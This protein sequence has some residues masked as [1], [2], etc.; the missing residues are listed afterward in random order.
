MI[1]MYLKQKKD[2]E[3]NIT[4]NFWLRYSSWTGLYFAAAKN[5]SWMKKNGSCDLKPLF[6]RWLQI[7]FIN[8]CFDG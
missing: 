6:L 1:Y 5:Q 8:N 2:K 4:Y 7:P 3:S